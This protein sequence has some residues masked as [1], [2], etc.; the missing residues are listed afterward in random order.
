M[1]QQG[2]FF[3][4]KL[5]EI[6]KDSDIVVMVRAI[7]PGGDPNIYISKVHQNPSEKSEGEI[8]S[9]ESKGNGIFIE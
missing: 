6:K 1:A 7:N 3:V 8:A 2:D 4:F 5:D 9:C